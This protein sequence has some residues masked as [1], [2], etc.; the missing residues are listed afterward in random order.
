MLR[1]Y[2]HCPEYRQ[3]IIDTLDAHDLVFSLSHHRFL[4]QQIL[5][6]QVL[7]KAPPHASD[8][9][10]SLLQDLTPKFPNAIAQV[11]H[12]FYL[13]EKRSEDILRTP[14]VI[15]AAAACLEIVMCEKHRRYC[16]EQWQKLDPSAD[17][18]R[19]QYY[20]QEF[21]QVD[22]RIKELKQ[23]RQVTFSEVTELPGAF[24]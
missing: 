19:K 17:L 6:L 1:I 2:L 18:Q 15:R 7:A 12:L 21:Y 3:T 20:W 13:D 10:I 5:E 9:L 8:P 24:R 16:L 11:A 23:N 4:W 14:L 22:Q